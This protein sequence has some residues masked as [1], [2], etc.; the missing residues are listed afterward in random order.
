MVEIHRL[1]RVVTEGCSEQLVLKLRLKRQEGT[2]QR[3]EDARL[4][5]EGKPSAKARDKDWGRREEQK[6]FV[7][8]VSGKPSN[9]LE[10]GSATLI[11]ICS[12]GN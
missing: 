4:Q 11:S 7:S 8:I 10:Q 1:F 2:G 6:G 9:N 12:W 5:A 3:V